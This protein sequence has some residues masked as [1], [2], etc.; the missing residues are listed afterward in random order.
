M[1]KFLFFSFFIFF[2]CSSNVIKKEKNSSL[3]TNEINLNKKY[4]LTLNDTN[5]FIQYNPINFYS[6]NILTT[7]EY[8]NKNKHLKKENYYNK[9][10]D[11]LSAQCYYNNE[12]NTLKS[13]EII[14]NNTSY[15]EIY[16][17]LGK[18]LIQ[19]N[20]NL[21]DSSEMLNYKNFKSKYNI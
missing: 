15:I 12:N 9:N 3:D 10:G 2:S 7:K 4:S 6:K 13:K 5:T 11:F 21:F 20:F 19:K 18:I 14:K 17:E 8:Y 1:K 16:S